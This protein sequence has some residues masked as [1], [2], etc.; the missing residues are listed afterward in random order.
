MCIPTIKEMKEWRRR[1]IWP[2]FPSSKG[3]AQ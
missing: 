2:F 1:L 3:D